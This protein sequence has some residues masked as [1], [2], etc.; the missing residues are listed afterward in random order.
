MDD[1]YW[2]GFVLKIDILYAQIKNFDCATVL[3][4][5]IK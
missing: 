3:V 4:F 2:V 5:I 1:L